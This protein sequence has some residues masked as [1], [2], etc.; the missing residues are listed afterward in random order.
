MSGIKREKVA[1]FLLDSCLPFPIAFARHAWFVIQ[2]GSR[3][4][5]WEFGKFQLGRQPGGFGLYHNFLPPFS[6]L[7]QRVGGGAHG[8]RY[9]AVV[10]AFAERPEITEPLARFIESKSHHYP[11]LE[12]YRYLG[13]NSNTYIQW[14]LNQFPELDWELPWNA[15]GKNYRF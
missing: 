2:R 10:R 13:P 1:V 6:G 8:K 12:Q 5:R 7:V 14:V 15:I 3:F 4:D 11:G 9:P